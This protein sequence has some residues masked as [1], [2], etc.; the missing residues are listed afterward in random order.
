MKMQ[1][2]VQ[3]FK[4]KLIEIIDEAQGTKNF[5]VEFT[6]GVN[7]DLF[8]GQL[9]MVRIEN[10]KTLIKPCGVCKPGGW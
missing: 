10:D 9:Y 1:Q 7:I 2:T 3:E 8:S 4:L 6:D 5:R